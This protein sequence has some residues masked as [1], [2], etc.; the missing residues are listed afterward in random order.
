MSRHPSVHRHDLDSAR[1]RALF[2]ALGGETV[3]LDNAGGSQVPRVVVDAMHR[4]LVQSYVQLGADYALSRQATA[5]VRQAHDVVSVLMNAGSGDAEAGKVILGASTSEL[6]NRLAQAY[7]E[8][9]EPGDEVIVSE[10]AHASNADPFMRLASGRGLRAAGLTVKTWR[11]DPTTG[12]ASLE[13]LRQ[14]VGPRTRLIAVPHVSNI[15]GA[16]LDLGP[17]VALARS[18]GARVLVDGVA[19]APHRA[20]D[21]TAWGVDWYV[22]STYK[23]FGPHAAALYG[24]HTALAEVT[25]PNHG[26]I[27]KEELP[28]KFELGGVNHEGT[29]GIAALPRYLAALVD[30]GERADQPLER[31]RVEAAFEV[32]TRL[33]LPLQV[34]LLEDLVRRPDV[35]VI[36]PISSGLE[37][38]GVVSFVHARRSS[39]EIARAA[40]ARG[41]GIRFGHFYAYRLCQALGLDP[42]DGVVR[43]SFAHYNTMAEVE[44]LIAFFDEVL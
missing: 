34:R 7:A 43:V 11:V 29:A 14:L 23:V 31:A 6:V 15:L 28:R 27:P 40:N 36:G 13:A 3:F 5:T 4:Y 16:V 19:Y 35:R 25:G 39:A 21:V 2:P 18:V 24:S 8:V 41:L 33:E 22:Y 1:V 42:D 26:F 32:I 17:V 12:E 44:R 20:I 30:E 9:W 10:A 38:V 37:R